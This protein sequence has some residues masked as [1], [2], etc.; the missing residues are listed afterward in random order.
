MIFPTEKN[1]RFYSDISDD[2]CIFDN[3]NEKC[4]NKIIHKMTEINSNKPDKE[5]KNI[6]NFR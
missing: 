4:V 1:D 2:E 6:I 3:Y 5:R